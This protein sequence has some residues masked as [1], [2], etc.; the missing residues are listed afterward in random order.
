MTQKL[1]D[2]AIYDAAE[3]CAAERLPNR[4]IECAQPNV[5]QAEGY[6]T[7]VET[8]TGVG[9]YIDVMHE[10]RLRGTFQD[11][12]GGGVTADEM[13]LLKEIASAVRWLSLTSYGKAAVPRDALARALNVYRHIRFLYPEPRMIFEIGGGSGYVG[14]LLLLAGYGYASTEISQAFYLYQNHLI[15][16]LAPGRIIELASDPCS[17]NEIDSLPLGSSVHVPWWKFTIPEPRFL[18]PIDAVTANHC[19]CEMHPRALA[20]SL[21]ASRKLLENRGPDACFVFEGWGSTV[22]NPVW[23]VNKRFWEL[24]FV[25]PHN[26]IR[27]T[28]YVRSESS[29]AVNAA[30]RE[31]PWASAVQPNVLGLQRIF[32]KAPQKPAPAS[33]EERYQPHYQPHIWVTPANALSRRITEGRHAIE[34]QAKQSETDYDSMLGEVLG[35]KD[36]MSQD[37]KFLR[38]IGISL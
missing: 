36:T 13:A 33:E 5:F 14:A 23:S 24:G 28:A 17:F 4:I 12:L 25:A 6:P 18:L 31:R 15:N 26:D 22:R 10:G 32:R 16:A 8:V 27:I 7:R 37:E 34:A 30:P 19:L 29:H 20:Y 38:S 9:R 11:M 3:R 1:L 35:S 21:L 2:P